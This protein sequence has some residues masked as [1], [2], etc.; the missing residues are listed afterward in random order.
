M[1]ERIPD[2]SLIKPTASVEVLDGIVDA[3]TGEPV[4]REMLGRLIFDPEIEGKLNLGP[5]TAGKTTL[6]G[7][8]IA[9]LDEVFP[10]FRYAVKYY[11]DSLRASLVP[12]TP[13]F[14]DQFFQEIMSAGD[15]VLVE[16]P[17][18]GETDFRDRGVTTFIRLTQSSKGFLFNYIVFNPSTQRKTGILRAI[19][20]DMPSEEVVRSLKD[21]Y[22]IEVV[23]T[24]GST[25]PKIVG[26]KIKYLIAGMANEEQVSVIGVEMRRQW[27]TLPAGETDELQEIAEKIILP[28]SYSA[29]VIFNDLVEGYG[30]VD[31]AS[32]DV[33]MSTLR[34]RAESFASYATMEAAYAT[35]N[36]N[37]LGIPHDRFRVVF[38][39]R[40]PMGT[41]WY[42]KM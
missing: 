24:S 9:F 5:P 28:E 27:T 2:L 42:L 1:A 3:F 6:M 22:K 26:E 17:G 29:E 18:V 36:F 39:P 19:V 21:D 7:Q 25:D 13:E 31:V 20:P 41:K 15:K 34:A 30:A 10:N 38:N 11:D 32:S 4:G 14:N 12:D 35:F 37:K 33:V 8:E 23:V 40:Q 16:L